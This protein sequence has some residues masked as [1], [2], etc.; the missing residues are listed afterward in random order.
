MTAVGIGGGREADSARG[1]G[2]FRRFWKEAADFTVFGML[3]RR[4][5]R[6]PSSP[7][8][9]Q[10]KEETSFLSVGTGEG[11]GAQLLE[12]SVRSYEN[13]AAVLASGNLGEGIGGDMFR[14]RAFAREFV[15]PKIR[16]GN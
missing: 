6:P 15:S 3:L 14:A 10:S 12:D 11:V 7:S 9:S 4:C 2:C 1:R 16:R 8:E 5:E 13:A